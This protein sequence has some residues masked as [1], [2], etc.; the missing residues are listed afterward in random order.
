MT[1]TR[2]LTV[3]LASAIAAGAHAAGPQSE[4]CR[5]WTCRIVLPTA[6][7]SLVPETNPASVRVGTLDIPVTEQTIIAPSE[8][9]ELYAC[10]G[11]DAFGD[12]ELMCLL[13]P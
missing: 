5:I 8:D 7:A 3:I 10:I 13:V 1:L 6:T 12:A 9:G 11:H 2:T 4:Q